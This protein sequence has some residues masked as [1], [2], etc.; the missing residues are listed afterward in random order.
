MTTAVSAYRS[1]TSPGRK[2]PSAFTRRMASESIAIRERRTLAARMRCS[3]QSA[4]GSWGAKP[5]MRTA[6][7]LSGE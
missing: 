3:I 1:M 6:M 4:G 5:I 7:R 2:S